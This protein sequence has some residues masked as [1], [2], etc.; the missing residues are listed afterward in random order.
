TTVLFTLSHAQ[1]NKKD[2]LLIIGNDSITKGEFVNTYQKNNRL[3]ET[4]PKE[5]RDYLD[6]FINFKLKV[7]EGK[8][9]QIDT[10]VAFQ[11]ELAS[12]ITQSAQ[13]YLI[14]H[15]VT[16]QLLEEGIERSKY[17]LRASHILVNCPQ[18]ATAKEDAVAY[19]KALNIRKEII[20]GLSFSDA[21]VKYS[22]D[23]SARDMINPQNGRMQYGNNGE[24]GY[25]TVL[26]LIYPFE[27]AAYNTP[28]GEI[29]MPIKTNFGYHLVYVQ[30]KV[31]AISKIA[32]SQIY[33]AD[34]L[35]HKNEMSQS[36]KTKVAEIGTKL[37]NGATF[38]DLVEEYSEDPASKDKNGEL[39]PFSPNRRA[40]IFV[41]TA[42][43]LQPEEVS[44]ALP[45]N[46]GWHF[47]KIK[48]VTPYIVDDEANYA[49]KNRLARDPRS[50]KSKDVL[51][52]KLK[53]EYSYNESGKKAA[54]K[55]LE[56]NI[57][58]TDFQSKDFTIE[59]LPE[60]EKLKP[61]FTFADQKV[62]VSDFAKH[63][64]RFQGI[65]LTNGITPFIN[66]RYPK[67][68]Q[69]VILNYEKDHLIEK[70]P[71]YKD[72]VAEY[73]DGMILYEINSQKVWIE[74]LKDSIGL[75]NYYEK[76]KTN[77][78]INPKADTIQYKPMNDIRA[79]VITEYQNYLDQEWVKELKKKYPVIINEE[80]YKTILKK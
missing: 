58:A 67:F 40:A 80:L 10:A 38:E 17:H 2:I 70:Y 3:S 6:L 31:P 42:L 47:I 1:D 36:T 25:F 76:I 11:R 43:T 33:I 49:L 32:I 20:N 77:Y 8:A 35:A 23:P 14:D 71:E 26:E 41:K 19:Q 46:M 27:T 37:K 12:Y 60:M 28:V 52:E 53:K 55:Y 9:L 13:Q 5:L 34:T 21:A 68:V 39:Q 59:D 79:I 30:D 4:S 18:N 7:K 44:E 54:F 51:V 66:E 64:L 62:L 48:E 56:K 24:L 78:P 65:N 69:E 63:L 73:Q 61:I 45:S 72:L 22:D 57:S 29:S 75:Q 50:H 15:D 74:A 16:E